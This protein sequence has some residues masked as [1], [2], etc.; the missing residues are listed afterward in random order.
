MDTAPEA[1]TAPRA[2]LELDGLGKLIVDYRH[3]WEKGETAYQVTGPRVRGA[4]TIT[5]EQPVGSDE[6]D[7]DTPYVYVQYGI[8]DRWGWGDQRRDRPVINRVRL[9]GGAVINTDTMRQRRLT[10][11]D[12]S[13]HR[14]VGLNCS[15]SAP[16]ATNQRCALVVHALIFHWLNHPEHYALRLAWARHHAPRQVTQAGQDIQRAWAAIRE[17]E[18]NLRAARQRQANAALLAA[19]PPGRTA[20]VAAA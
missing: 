6:L 7:V 5:L 3:D 8:G 20:A 13:C 19:M 14:S 17:Q 9:L 18:A 11:R 12:V 10:H 16:T 15:T 4:F 2:E 1:A